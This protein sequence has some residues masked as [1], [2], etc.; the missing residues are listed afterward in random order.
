MSVTSVASAEVSIVID[1]AATLGSRDVVLQTGSESVILTGGFTVDDNSMP[2]GNVIVTV[3]KKTLTI[4]GDAVA[5]HVLVVI[6]NS[7]TIRVT[8]Q[9]GTTINGRVGPQDFAAKSI[10]IVNLGGG[11]DEL[12][13]I[14]NRANA[15]KKNA[16][17]DMGAG[18]DVLRLEHLS[19]KGRARLTLGTGADHLTLLDTIFSK[20]T[21]SD[22]NEDEDTLEELASPAPIKMPKIRADRV[23]HQGRGKS[24]SK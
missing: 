12:R 1:A 14:S 20:Q 17:F 10:A 3:G 16:A 23:S 22:F 18:D 15:I 19:I 8:G 24:K 4:T 6:V 21:T 2:L 9:D 5:N 7:K 11:N 13:V